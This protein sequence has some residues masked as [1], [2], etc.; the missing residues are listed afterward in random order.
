MTRAVPKSAAA[1]RRLTV[2]PWQASIL[3]VHNSTIK[4]CFVLNW[5]TKI[6]LLWGKESLTLRAVKV[7]KLSIRICPCSTLHYT[8]RD[9]F[10]APVW[11]MEIEDYMRMEDFPLSWPRDN[12]SVLIFMYIRD[13]KSSIGQGS[14]TCVPISFPRCALI[15]FV[16]WYLSNK[17]KLTSLGALPGIHWPDLARFQHNSFLWWKSTLKTW[18]SQ[19][20]IWK[21]CVIFY[22][23]KKCWEMH[24]C[25]LLGR[26]K[27][28]DLYIYNLDVYLEYRQTTF[29]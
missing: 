5:N 26:L 10:P 8:E 27:L 2:L 28:D 6:K 11:T 29:L 19:I 24:S 18:I 22:F 1:V 21:N 9:C 17:Q 4:I 3:G 14:D 12:L 16:Y 20:V 15:H 13:A 7:C 23:N 25:P